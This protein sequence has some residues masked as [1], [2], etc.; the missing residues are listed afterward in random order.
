MPAT[1]ALPVGTSNSVS[2]P[3]GAARPMRLSPCSVNHTA[4]STP[5]AIAVGSALASSAV[6]GPRVPSVSMRP[7]E[8]VARSVNHIAPSDPRAM[9]KGEAAG[10]S[11]NSVSSGGPAALAAGTKSATETRAVSRAPARRPAVEVRRSTM[12]GYRQDGRARPR[13]KVGGAS[14]LRP[15]RTGPSAANPAGSER[16]PP[17][18]ERA[19]GSHVRSA[20][21][22]R[23]GGGGPDRAV[24]V[25]DDRIVDVVATADAPDGPR[26]IDLAGH[27]LLPDSWTCIHT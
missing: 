8:S 9:P 23:A 25:E 10:A 13:P 7:I 24:I 11:G 15:P 26:R 5:V 3:S 1:T 21:R 17:R 16:Y 19:T 18:H 20:D 27:T 14:D 6:H 2:V 22:H 12:S 4:P